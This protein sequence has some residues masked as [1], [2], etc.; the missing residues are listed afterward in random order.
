MTDSVVLKVV[1]MSRS[2]LFL[3]HVNFLLYYINMNILSNEEQNS[4]EGDRRN[5]SI[6]HIWPS[7]RIFLCFIDKKMQYIREETPSL[8]CSLVAFLNR[9]LITQV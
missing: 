2:L 1:L 4:S 9:G 8:N 6:V 7:F 3:M 5:I